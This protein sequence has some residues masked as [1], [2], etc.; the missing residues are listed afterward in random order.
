MIFGLDS[1]SNVSNVDLYN[2]NNSQVYRGLFLLN[3]QTKK[4]HF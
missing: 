4:T 1:D 2:I 3:E